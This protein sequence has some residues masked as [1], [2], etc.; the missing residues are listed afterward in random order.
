MSANIDKFA[1]KNI[2][3]GRVCLKWKNAALNSQSMRLSALSKFK[4]GK[5]PTLLGTDVASRG[6][7]IPTTDVNLIHE[8][9]AEVGK[10]MELYNYREITD[11]LECF[12]L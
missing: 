9:E 10:Q 6:L 11:S 8:I 3:K 2:A 7:E 4:S 1:V 12:T 5:V